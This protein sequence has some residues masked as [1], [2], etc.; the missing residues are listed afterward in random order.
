M[1]VRSDASCPELT[2]SSPDTQGSCLVES[3]MRAS[4]LSKPELSPHTIHIRHHYAPSYRSGITVDTIYPCSLIGPVAC[5]RFR[6]PMRFLVVSAETLV[7][8]MTAEEGITVTCLSTLIDTLVSLLNRQISTWSIL[9][10]SNEIVG[11]RFSAE[12]TG[13][14][15]HLVIRQLVDTIYPCSLI[16]PVACARVRRLMRSLFVSAETLVVPLTAEEGITVTC[17]STLIDTLVS[18]LNRQIS[19]WSILV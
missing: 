7:V 10:T 6:R 9:V 12:K 18:L 2:S 11:H 19:T 5:A 14:L 15:R 1:K 3:L 8:P 17:L 13:L 4:C 16:G